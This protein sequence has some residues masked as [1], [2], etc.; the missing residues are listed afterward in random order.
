MAKR[1]VS[2]PIDQALRQFL[3]AKAHAEEIGRWPVRFG[4]CWPRRRGRRLA[5]VRRRDMDR[6]WRSAGGSR[7]M[8]SAVPVRGWQ[9]IEPIHSRLRAGLRNG[10]TV[11]EMK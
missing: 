4:I 5:S 11:K 3:E 6:T 10:T 9:G 8:R 2:V 1:T 7:P